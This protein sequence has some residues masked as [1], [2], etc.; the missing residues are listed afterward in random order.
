M[1]IYNVRYAGTKPKA[2]LLTVEVEFAPFK[3]IVVRLVSG[4]ASVHLVQYAVHSHLAEPA[5][6]HARKKRVARGRSRWG[7]R[8]L[9]LRKVERRMTVSGHKVECDRLCRCLDIG[10][11]M[12][13]DGKVL[14]RTQRVAR[15]CQRAQGSIIDWDV[16][17]ANGE[18]AQGAKGVM[19]SLLPGP[20]VR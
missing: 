14:K 13:R 2:A 4:V 11:G 17:I 16:A 9:Q 5:M 18:L 15:G 10:H 20:R 7:A 8:Q 1:S 3:Y 19:P 6:K 12:R